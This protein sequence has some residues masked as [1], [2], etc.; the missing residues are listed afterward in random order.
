MNKLISLLAVLLLVSACSTQIQQEVSTTPETSGTE[1]S[2]NLGSQ[3]APSTSEPEQGAA[4]GITLSILGQHNSRSDCWV[5]YKGKAYDVTSFLPE[6]PGGVDAIAKRCGTATE[7]EQ[8][9]IK[10]HG[11][12]KVDLFMKVASFKGNLVI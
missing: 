8:A 2:G 9:F 5:G 10:K 3:D 12:S 11:E 1:P 7:F 4:E 6:H